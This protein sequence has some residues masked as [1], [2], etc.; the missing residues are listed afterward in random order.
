MKVAYALWAMK[1]CN[2]YAEG[3]GRG[4]WRPQDNRPKRNQAAVC[5][6]VFDSHD[7][8]PRISLALR[9]N[10]QDPLAGVEK[11]AQVVV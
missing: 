2:V 6:L 7:E 4:L 10:V 1:A 3:A 11:V 9:I 5:H 8:H